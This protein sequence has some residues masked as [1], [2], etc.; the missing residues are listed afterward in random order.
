MPEIRQ[1]LREQGLGQYADAFEENEIDQSLLLDLSDGDLKEL[2]MAAMGH[3]KRLLKAVAS[4]NEPQDAPAVE[5]ALAL[6][7]GEVG[8][9]GPG[10]A[11]SKSSRTVPQREAERRQITVLFCDLVGST[12]LAESLDPEDLRVLM[13]AYQQACGTVIE[14]HGGHVAQYLGDGLMV[15]FGWPHAH[16]D[17]A[18]RAVRAGLGII[19]RISALDAAP[20]LAVRLG[21]ATGLVVVGETGGGDPSVA[22][23]ATGETPNIAARLQALAE[24][25]SLFISD[26]TRRLI[27][28]AFDVDDLGPQKLKGV[29]T[30]VAI[31]RVRGERAMAT[32]FE[33]SQQARLT[34]LVG[35]DEEVG[36]LLKRWEQV[37]DGDGQVVVLSGEPGIGKSRISQVFRERLANTSQIRL[38]YQCSPYHAFSAFHPIIEQIKRAA[39]FERGDTSEVQLDKLEAL[40]GGGGEASERETALF[41]AMVSLPVARYADLGLSPQ[42]QKEETI[43]ALVE[44]TMALAA[45]EPVL[46]IFED[47]HW[48]DPTSLE[49]L[50]ALIARL[51]ESAVFLLITCRPEFRAPWAGEGH[52]TLHSLNR[53]GRRQGADLV[54]NAAGGKALPAEVRDEII[55][56]TDGVPLFV[57]ELTR[58]VI[59]AGFLTETADAYI[60]EGPLLPLAIPATLQDSLMARLDHL[61]PVK[62]TAQ[63]GAC[64]GREF[65]HELLAVISP[66]DEMALSDALDQL[67]AAALIFRRG[68]LPHTSYTFKHALVQDAAYESLLKTRRRELHARIS[69]ALTTRFPHIA[70]EHPELLAHHEEEAGQMESAIAH[71]Q[72]A[73]KQ[74]MARSANTEAL[75]HFRQSLGLV[76]SLPHQPDRARKELELRILIGTPLI[77]TTAHGSS[78][79]GENFVRAAALCNEVD[80]PD[81]LFPALYGQWVN[82]HSTARHAEARPISDRFL[83]LAERHDDRIGRLQ[84]HRLSGVLDVMFLDLE[85][86][87]DNL[88]KAV[89]LYD[90]EQDRGLALR[91][92]QDPGV[93]ALSFLATAHALCG[94][95]AKSLA[96]SEQA[97]ALADDIGHKFTRVYGLWWAVGM[98][99]LIQRD[100]DRGAKAAAEIVELSKAEGFVAWEKTAS[101]VA[102]HFAREAGSVDVV[103]APRQ[104]RELLEETKMFGNRMLTPIWQA[105]IV[106]ADVAAGHADEA[107]KCLGE[108]ILLA[109]ESAE[110]FMLPELQRIRGSLRLAVEGDGAAAEKDFRDA[111]ALA[112]S[113]GAGLFALRTA[114]DLVRLWQDQGRG[115][116]GQQLLGDIHAEFPHLGETPEWQLARTLMVPLR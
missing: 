34:P 35:R 41:A 39:R 33:A 46:M 90:P 52:V 2:G 91:Y 74:A 101:L 54:A 70:A 12:A 64:I 31:H 6:A 79:V 3:R 23:T 55:A 99:T 18:A 103:A 111:I 29:S 76:G 86:A 100:H 15:Y 43:A 112:Q 92:G 66:L 38:R 37:R 82:L 96:L 73:G 36:L 68:A 114:L 42:R 60:L 75:R 58:M 16:E 65:S 48:I 88:R 110:L 107:I 81:L 17:D 22:K 95:R 28:G 59:E 87:K 104:L 102:L 77:A 105:S 69:E 57:E 20:A 7:P 63:I 71:W 4:L 50:D 115:S 19:D 51:Q 25:G 27:G 5:D 106:E 1:W 13:A 32:R 80:D 98:P 45:R 94:E 47:V 49:V 30:P 56:K 62:E 72:L 109:R 78:E 93:A 84:G 44:S 67:I 10:E 89:A 108:V 11:V 9:G 53:L 40:L 116:A 14:S 24:P 61:T 113:H 83:E 21:I 85:S 26:S 97:L 8:T